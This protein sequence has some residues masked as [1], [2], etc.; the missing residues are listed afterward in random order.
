MITVQYR[1][2]ILLRLNRDLDG[3]AV[4][5]LQE[6]FGQFLP[7]NRRMQTVAR[8]VKIRIP[9]LEKTA[10]EDLRIQ[11]K[12]L[13]E[14]IQFPV[15]DQSAGQQQPISGPAAQMVQRLGLPCPAF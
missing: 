2:S 1:V 6:V 11:E 3:D 13:A 12:I 5:A 9:E 14:N 10:A 4:Q 15:C 8:H 7:E